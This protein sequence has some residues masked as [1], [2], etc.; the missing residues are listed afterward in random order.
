MLK[1]IGWSS[2]AFWRL[3]R[4]TWWILKGFGVLGWFAVRRTWYVL[5]HPNQWRKKKRHLPE[6]LRVRSLLNRSSRNR[7]DL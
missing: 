5:S 7:T 3:R 1:L 6:N 4:L 2:Y